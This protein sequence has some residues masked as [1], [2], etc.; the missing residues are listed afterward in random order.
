MSGRFRTEAAISLTLAWDPRG[1][2]DER[3]VP[4]LRRF[5][6]A[7][8]ELAGCSAMSVAGDVSLLDRAIGVGDLAV[9]DLP[10]EP[11]LTYEETVQKHCLIA[12][13]RRYEGNVSRVARALE[14][15][16]ET[17]HSRL[18]RFGI[19]AKEFKPGHA[20][21]SSASRPLRDAVNA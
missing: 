19:S 13:L 14:I 1:P 18:C 5:L 3:D 4:V 20:N 2:I 9:A 11:G 6:A 15:S 8:R 10:A 12:A 16:R 7:V 21:G 17:V